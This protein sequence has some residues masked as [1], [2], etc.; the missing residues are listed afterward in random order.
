[1]AQLDVRCEVRIPLTQ[2]AEASI[3]VLD[4][5]CVNIACTLSADAAVDLEQRGLLGLGLGRL[6][7]LGA[8]VANAV[9]QP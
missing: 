9:D 3:D 4:S 8:V 6:D 5:G 1:M 7:Q 2:G